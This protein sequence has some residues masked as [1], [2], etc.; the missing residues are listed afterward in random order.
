MMGERKSRNQKLKIEVI[1]KYEKR[2]RM[3]KK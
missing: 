1:E 3:G 2:G